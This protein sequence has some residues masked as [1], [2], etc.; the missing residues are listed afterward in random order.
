MIDITPKHSFVYDGAQLNVYHANIGEGLTKHEH[1]YAH[2]TIC[3]SGSCKV[4]L[5]GRHYIIDK[6]STPL[7]L[8]AGEWHEIEALEDETVFVNVFAEGKY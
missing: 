4:T 1:I 8:P 2:G 5:E 3:H 7:N 6:N